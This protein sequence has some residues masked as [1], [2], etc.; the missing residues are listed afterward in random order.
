LTE[1]RLQNLWDEIWDLLES[2]RSGEAVKAARAALAEIGDE[3]EIR[4]LLGL[5][6]LDLDEVGAARRELA[7][8]VAATPE[9]G[10]AAAALAWAD[11][12]A[13]DF[14][15]AARNV[16]RALALDDR[17]PE[18][19]YLQGLVA[20]R[21]GDEELAVSS[22]AEARRLDPE[23]YPEPFEV[24]EDEFLRV[25]QDAVL[26]LDEKVRGVLEETAI[27]VQ[28]FPAEELL[29]DCDPP[30]DPQL[31]GLFVGRSLL[32][33]SVQDSGS[34]P[35]TM[36]LFQRNIERAVTTREELEEEIRIT[37]LHEIAHHF[38][39]DEDEIEARGLA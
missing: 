9:W 22:F 36:Y 8:V 10:E 5:A 18:A 34:L 23:R 1:E 4:Y 31:L 25:A 16:G 7:A 28:P 26:E 33:Q 15:A 2:G 17:I 11:F 38:G 14:A 3:A 19:H 39:W 24:D 29:R 21:A 30:L 6:L 32:E 13:C 27:F 35:N 12:H 20:E 37:A